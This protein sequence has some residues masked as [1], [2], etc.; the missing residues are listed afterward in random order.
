MSLSLL[1]SNV[2]VTG[3]NVLYSANF[4]GIG[5]AQVFV[6]GNQ[7]FISGGAGGTAGTGGG[8][9]QG[10][11][12]ALSGFTTGISGALQTQISSSSA[13]VSNVNGLSG[14]LTLIGGGG[15][16]INTS[17][18]TIY[19]T[20]KNLATSGDII[21]LSGWTNNTFSTIITTNLISG[22]LIQ[23]GVQLVNAINSLSG[24][25]TGLPVNFSGYI[26]TGDADIR[27][28]PL[29]TNPSGYITAD[30]LS[31]TDVYYFN[32]Q[33]ADIS[34]FKYMTR[35][36]PTGENP[37]T[38]TFTITSNNQYLTGFIN[39]TG[40]P[41]L[42]GLL[43]GVDAV[44]IL[45]NITASNARETT[46]YYKLLVYDGNTS[47]EI[48]SSY[49]SAFLQTSLNRYILGT[50][51]TGLNITP[52]DRTEIQFYATRGSSGPDA[53]VKLV[54]GGDTVAR[55]AIPL[56]NDVLI[57]TYYLNTNPSGFITS[58]QTGQFYPA[59]NPQGYVTS[60]DL[61]LTGSQS[62]NAANNNGINLSGN[63]T[64]SGIILVNK[65]I[66]ISGILTTGITNTGAL[67][68]AAINSLSGY[69][70]NTVV[71]RTG[72]EL[73]SGAKRFQISSSSGFYISSGA[74]T[75][76]SVT[77][78][79][80]IISLVN[81]NSVFD[82]AQTLLWDTS[83]NP[84][85]DWNSR[86]AQDVNA[87]I[88][89]DWANK[90]LADASGLTSVS[91]QNRKLS[92]GGATTTVLDWG[93]KEILGEWITTTTGVQ[94]GS[95]VN[96]YR[97]S[98]LSGV[99]VSNYTALNTGLSGFLINLINASSAGVASINGA[100]GVLTIGGAT[101]ISVTT[102]GQ[103]ITISG[104]TG[105]YA[106]FAQKT[107]LTT[108]GQTLY[109][110]ILGVSGTSAPSTGVSNINGLTGAIT[111]VGK[112]N[113]AI[114]VQ[115]QTINISGIASPSLPFIFNTYSFG[116]G[117]ASNQFIPFGNNFSINPSV[118]GNLIND[119]GDPIL[120]CH[121]SGINTSGFYLNFSDTLN[122]NNYLYKYYAT[123]GTG[124]F[125]I[126]G[127]STP[128][129]SSVY[130]PKIVTNNYGLTSS[131]DVVV[132][133]KIAGIT[134]TLPIANG[135]GKLY[136]IKNINVGSLLITG[137]GLDTIDGQIN[138]TLAQWGKLSVVDYVVN[139]WIIV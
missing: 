73:V 131:D 33:N 37:V 114:S 91:W 109:N 76:F 51:I 65:D 62:W 86:Y 3:S 38:G 102:V 135:G 6:S 40:E 57:N 4:T 18:Q 100:S 108:T 136:I 55:H 35:S 96:F 78:T 12:D 89:L 30:E 124:Y 39:K 45:A 43:Q 107:A 75:L 14:A 64:Q 47:R 34:G 61:A 112:G 13:G 138:Q 53:T 101:N 104:D 68:S 56:T 63:L 54:F 41:G 36:I 113:V 25:V 17:G 81:G 110:L 69:V 44:A 52:T 111:L 19:I 80:T 21:G 60:G 129:S 97:I 92:A 85:I 50:I 122:T 103:N 117:E 105:D 94:S 49:T 87:A 32:S 58:G 7:I 106:L 123:T 115:N 31:F 23:T 128:T 88:V 11:L 118:V 1:I 119:S 27:Y 24:Y 121:I 99:L 120:A 126:G 133:N 8:I 29:G 66:L 22:N 67:L 5:G 82:S 10:Q 15:I 77:P 90:F 9:T 59:S 72:N 127:G 20:G 139:K 2:K 46:L 26:T 132:F 83:F 137:N 42:N 16:Q 130:S 79:S 98:G 74:R 125:D 93:T 95:L 71:H 134:G 70:D 48:N 84:S 28:Y 116:S